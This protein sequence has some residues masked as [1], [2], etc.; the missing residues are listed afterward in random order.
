MHNLLNQLI[1]HYRDVITLFSLLIKSELTFHF[2]VILGFEFLGWMKYSKA[3]QKM[4]VIL[5]LYCFHSLSCY[6]RED[7]LSTGFNLVIKMNYKN[8]KFLLLRNR[9]SSAATQYYKTVKFNSAKEPRDDQ[10]LVTRFQ[11]SHWW[12]LVNSRQ[13]RAEGHF[14]LPPNMLQLKKLMQCDLLTR[15]AHFKGRAPFFETHQWFF[16][17]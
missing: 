16:I 17:T 9:R 12:N 6:Y 15:D 10:R 1:L 2:S 7:K 13:V 4:D 3:E 8:F 5:W 14:T 11:L